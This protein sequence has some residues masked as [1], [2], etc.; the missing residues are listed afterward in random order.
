MIQQP[1]PTSTT[2][3]QE[4]TQSKVLPN[5]PNETQPT[6]NEQLKPVITNS[7]VS[8]PA[9]NTEVSKQND[10]QINNQSL[11]TPLTIQPN[12]ITNNTVSNTNT[13][14]SRLDFSTLSN[15]E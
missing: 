4:T 9:N 7:I 10:S 3:Q 1:T 5:I 8:V 6:L 14:P 11:N 12:V 15:L 13:M 2:E